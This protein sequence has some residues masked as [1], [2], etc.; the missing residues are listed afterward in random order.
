MLLHITKTRDWKPD[1]EKEGRYNF[2][3][4]FLSATRSHSVM[5]YKYTQR[6]FR[7]AYAYEIKLDPQTYIPSYDYKGKDT[8]TGE[9]S[10]LIRTLKKTGKKAY[11]ITNCIDYPAKEFA[12]VQLCDMIVVFDLSIV[13]SSTL[14]TVK[15]VP[16]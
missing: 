10:R 2:P 3:A 6:Y 16:S 14:C 4:L 7:K 15:R 11:K 13:Q 9:F 8:Y 12:E 5:Y 1:P